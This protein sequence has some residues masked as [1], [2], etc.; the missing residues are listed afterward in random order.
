MEKK[1]YAVDTTMPKAKHLRRKL[2]KSRKDIRH[3]K[4]L[5]FLVLIVIIVMS[6]SF[7]NQQ[8]QISSLQQNYA[9]IKTEY[10]EVIA[11]YTKLSIEYAGLRAEIKDKEIPEKQ[12]AEIEED[13]NNI[14]IEEDNNN[15]LTDT[16]V[17]YSSDPSGFTYNSDIPLSEDI[18]KYAYNKCQ[19]SGIDYP[20]FLGLMRKE[21]TFNPEAVSKTNDYGL[22]QINK[23]NHKLMREIF[24]SDWDP[25]NP[26]DNIDASIFILSEC[27]KDY[28]CENYHILLMNYNMG[29]GNAVECFNNG[30]Y[31]SN[32]SRTIMEYA[33]EY[34][35][36]GDGTVK[37]S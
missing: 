2:A 24:G 7:M 13:I 23:G 19:E 21:S 10:G 27:I 33:K 5:N 1:V 32:Y 16:L 14:L 28:N 6:I 4:I 25:L 22:C 17:Q 8:K 29:H 37:V 9:D 30:I 26:Y 34:G 12:S 15:I 18:Q 3:L 35:Y 36:S 11:S 31:S 20:V